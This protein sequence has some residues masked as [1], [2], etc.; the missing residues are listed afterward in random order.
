MRGTL[1]APEPERWTVAREV[2][3][4][5]SSLP[6]RSVTSQCVIAYNGR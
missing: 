1:F 5:A 4:A 6:I 3:K 2:S